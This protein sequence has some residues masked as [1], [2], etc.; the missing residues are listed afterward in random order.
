MALSL[1]NTLL[2]IFDHLT[3]APRVRLAVT[4]DLSLHGIPQKIGAILLEMK[5][6]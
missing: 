4:V 5:M 3:N 2:K 1:R 6:S